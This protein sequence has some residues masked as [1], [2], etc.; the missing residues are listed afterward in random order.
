MTYYWTGS[1]VK[2]AEVEI[3]KGITLRP[4]RRGR[5]GVR[6]GLDARA[7]A[8]RLPLRGGLDRHPE[9][10]Q[11][12]RGDLPGHS[13]AGSARSRRRPGSPHSAVCSR[14]GTN[15][16]GGYGHGWPGCAPCRALPGTLRAPRR[17]LAEP[18][19]SDVPTVP[20]EVLIVAL[21]Y[22]LAADGTMQ[23]PLLERL[24]V[25]LRVA[26]ANPAAR[27]LVSGGQPRSGVTEADLMARWLVE[28][29]W[30][31][32]AD[33]DRGQGPGHRRQRAQRRQPDAAAPRRGG[34]PGDQRQPYTPRAHGARGGARASRHARQ[35][36]SRGGPRPTFVRGGGRG[37][38]LDERL[39]VCRDLMRVSGFGPI[40]ACSNSIRQT[41]YAGGNVGSGHEGG[42][43]ESSCNRHRRRALARVTRLVAAGALG[44][45]RLAERHHHRDGVARRHLPCLR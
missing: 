21:G 39:V 42:Q 32:T 1:D 30:T 17:S 22:A 15:D 24:D 34:A 28:K 29:E 9:E 18:L 40:R 14:I 12:G 26:E 36:R 25:A 44:E 43:R 45:A 33:R 6:G 8:A 19:S 7:R 27:V 41:S 38:G 3:F 35:G 37:G 31:R 2:R 11:R 23:K 16:A 13:G 4:L 5:G 10:D 20:G